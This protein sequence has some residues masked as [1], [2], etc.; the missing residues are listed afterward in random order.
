M[1]V[2]LFSTDWDCVREIIVLL[3]FSQL[4]PRLIN[5]QAEIIR[6]RE[7]VKKILLFIDRRDICLVSN[8][9]F[10]WLLGILKIESDKDIF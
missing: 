7:I 2:N 5:I 6:V 3:F 9:C 1:F 10:V 8:G 4:F